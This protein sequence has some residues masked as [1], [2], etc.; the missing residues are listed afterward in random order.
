[1]GLGDLSD[2]FSKVDDILREMR[3]ISNTNQLNTINVLERILS[4]D[5]SGTTK[6][7]FEIIFPGTGDVYT[8]PAGTTLLD[9]D[10]GE[11]ILSDGNVIPMSS[12][13]SMHGIEYIRSLYVET[14]KHVT[15]S[16]SET[17]TVR[18]ISGGDYDSIT[19]VNIKNAK[20]ISV[21]DTNVKIIAS[22]DPEGVPERIVIPALVPIHIESQAVNG[23]DIAL[24]NALSF[25]IT[26]FVDAAYIRQILVTQ[27]TAGAANYTIEIWETDTYNPA[28][29][30]DLIRRIFSRDVLTDEWSELIEDVLLY[31]DRDMTNELH[32]RIVNNV[33]GTASDFDVAVKSDIPSKKV[34]L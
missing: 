31:V 4:N 30:S 22:N 25:D 1:M 16:V 28:T 19:Y 13:L 18:E 33:G 5:I 26:G 24:G 32:M 29:R 11:V 3:D 27:L 2:Y 8:L 14:S 15:L 10:G 12:S 6:Y 9:F 7:A 20:I 34:V 23:G 17:G 21:E